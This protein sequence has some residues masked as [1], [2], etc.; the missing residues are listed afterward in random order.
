MCRELNDGLPK[1]MA[2]SQP[3]EHV[4]ITLYGKRVSIT[5]FDTGHEVKHLKGSLSWIFQVGTKSNHP[6]PCKCESE[7]DLTGTRG[8]HVTVKAE[9]K[10]L[11]CCVYKSGNAGNHQ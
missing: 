4:N 1:V 9:I 2:V 11:E 10:R 5:F 7:G 3:L 8:V 6:C